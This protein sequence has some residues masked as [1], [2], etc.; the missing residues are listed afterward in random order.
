MKTKPFVSAP[1]DGSVFMAWHVLWKCWMPIKYN[2]Q[3]EYTWVDGTYSASWPSNAFTHWR[4]MDE[5]PN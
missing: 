2:T 3:H 1:R 5:P 4:A